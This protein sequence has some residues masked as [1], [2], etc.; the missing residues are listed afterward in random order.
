[1]TIELILPPAIIFDRSNFS[2][3]A[4]RSKLQFVKMDKHNLFLYRFLFKHKILK[5]KWSIR[6]F[7][8]NRKESET[9]EFISCLLKK[10]L[11]NVTIEFGNK[12][13]WGAESVL[14]SAGSSVQLFLI[15]QSEA[16]EAE[17]IMKADDIL[18]TIYNNKELLL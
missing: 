11:P 16:D 13:E 17:F 14:C 12:C 3:W 6:G 15:F 8:M 4:G 10:E 1:M 2:N 18:K 7:M 5:I 9:I